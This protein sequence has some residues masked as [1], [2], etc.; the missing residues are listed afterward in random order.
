MLR[1]N[2]DYNNINNY[3]NS[4]YF[5]TAVREARNWSLRNKDLSIL[6]ELVKVTMKQ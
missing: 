1:K 2:V 5:I 6:Q 3:R 4:K